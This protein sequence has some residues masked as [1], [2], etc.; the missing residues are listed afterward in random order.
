[1][2]K[3]LLSLAC[4][5]GLTATA[6]ADNEANSLAELYAFNE[7][8]TVLVKCPLTVTYFNSVDKRYTYVTDGTTAGLIFATTTPTY[9]QGDIIP[10]GEWAAKWQ[11]YSQ[12]L[13]EMIPSTPAQMPQ[14]S[15]SATIN[16]VEIAAANVTV[17][18]QSKYVVVKNVVLDAATPNGSVA[19]FTGTVGDVTINFR[20]TYKLAGVAAGTY[21]IT[22]IISV[23]NGNPQFIPTA[24][25]VVSGGGTVTNPKA[26]S[27][28][29]L[30]TKTNKD[31]ATVVT[32]DFAMNVTAT[33]AGDTRYM[34]V[35]DG[36]DAALIYGSGM[37]AAVPCQKVNKG[38]DAT[39]KVYNGLIEIIPNTPAE[40]PVVEEYSAVTYPDATSSAVVEANLNKVFTFRNVTFAEATPDKTKTAFTGT[41][42]AGGEIP[43]F[44]TFKLETVAAGTYDVVAVVS[45]FN[46][47]QVLPLAFV[48]PGTDTT[49]EVPGG[50]G[51]GGGGDEGTVVGFKAPTW[52]YEGSEDMVN[53][54]NNDGSETTPDSTTEQG[55]LV[56]KNFTNGSVAIVFGHGT[57]N[58]YT[59][60][61]GAEVRMYASGETLTIT[62]AT[63]ATITKVFFQTAPNSKGAPA[64]SEGTVEGE[65][66][67]VNTPVTWTGEV[68][69]HD[70][71]F[72]A[73]RQLRFRYI[74][75][76]YEGGGSVTPK[77]ATPSINP[78]GGYLISGHQE[79]SISCSTEGASIY[80]TLDGSNPTASSNK[81]TDAFSVTSAC[82]VK[83]I[84]M[85]EGYLDSAIA[86]AEFK[87]PGSVEDI[88]SFYATNPTDQSKPEVYM[89][90]NPVS[91][92]YQSG[93]YLYLHDNTGWILA[94]GKLDNTYKNGDV[95]NGI[96]GSN[97]VYNG[98]HQ[99]TPVAA[100]FGSATAGA[101][102]EPNVYQCEELA[103]DMA[104]EY[105]QVPACTITKIVDGDKVSYTFSDETAD[106]V[107][108]DQ[109]KLN[110]IPEEPEGQYTITGFV[111]NYKGTLEVFPVTIWDSAVEGVNA[112]ANVVGEVYY[113]LQGVRVIEPAKGQVA[114]RV[115][116]LS[117]GSVRASKVVVR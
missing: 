82:T 29:D 39:V 53:L 42:A 100:T 105:V 19:N 41:D 13:I 95:L 11:N 101:T 12:G 77:C 24:F 96:A 7:G 14:P 66:T 8:E 72:T 45:S 93:N 112:D 102:I 40:L 26:T 21:H 46:A 65:G 113:N 48:A 28:A 86:S 18:N 80:Y 85:A 3:F 6:V 15:G 89:F 36:T 1:M 109:F 79:V 110:I 75:V 97:T 71:V 23:Y 63:G 107:L 64:A 35:T 34:Y 84:A 30:Y 33:P 116:T 91:A 81:Y 62:P 69:G 44:N 61:F 25:E 22:G 73:S 106:V 27:I 49:P 58:N 51:G 114:I 99:M 78:N 90:T 31:G 92:V 4:L 111:A 16:P 115:A 43:F 32:V 56:G 17:A 76:T 104:H 38:W 98:A 5:F 55:S 10:G 57:G 52:N 60:A 47:L 20:N 9:K 54:I 108:Y 83:A 50:G 59:A 74:L 94:F 70:L 87:V 37:P 117:D 103:T 68:A 2:K 67:G 88:E